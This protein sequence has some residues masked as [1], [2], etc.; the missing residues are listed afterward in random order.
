MTEPT[1]EA[2]FGPK[3]DIVR[4]ALDRDGPSTV[5]ELMRATSLKREEVYGA[6]GWLTRENKIQMKMRGRTTLF[7]LRSE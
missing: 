7:L 5:E 1:F 4:E 3:V 2:F 6:L